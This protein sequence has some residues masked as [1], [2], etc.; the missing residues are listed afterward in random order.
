MSGR[1]DKTPKTVT[2]VCVHAWAY[3]LD[4]DGNATLNT[5]YCCPGWGEMPDGW[6][7][8]TRRELLSD[9]GIFDIED[10]EDHDSQDDAMAEA[11]R[12]AERLGCN[13][14]AY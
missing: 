2:T 3:V 14:T 8:Y 12:R 7:V 11:Q 5:T 4:A 1:M 10:D 6:T 13:V 9:G